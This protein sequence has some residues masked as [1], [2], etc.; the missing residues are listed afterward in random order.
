MAFQRKIFELDN[1][2]AIQKTCQY[3]LD[4]SKMIAIFGYE[5]A[6][7]TIGLSKFYG[8]NRATRYIRVRKA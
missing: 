7:K 4:N 5:G 6:G 1:F 3:A 2:L 8:N